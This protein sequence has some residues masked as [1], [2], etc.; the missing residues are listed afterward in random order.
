MAEQ[1]TYLAR[2]KNGD[3]GAF[4]H[5]VREHQSMVFS[6][7]LHFFRNYATAEEV[8][9]DVFLDL[10]RGLSG[11]ESAAHLCAWLKR[12][13][14]NRCIDRSRRKAYRL[15][16]QSTDLDLAG[17]STREPDVLAYAHIAEE[18]AKLPEEQRAIVILRYGEEMM[19]NEIANVLQ[20]PVNTVKSRLH[21]ALESL[22][23]TVNSRKAQL[24]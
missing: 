5:L 8:G 24:I 16:V 3:V 15:E 6:T 10:Y 11:V 1:E 13:T 21:R 4:E 14:L 22:R 9:Q 17:S 12:N 19:P 20:L 2:A 7:A 23:A 18:V